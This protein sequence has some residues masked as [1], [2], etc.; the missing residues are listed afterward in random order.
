MAEV[1]VEN[2]RYIKKPEI[3]EATPWTGDNISVMHKQ[4][5]KCSF[6]IKENNVL[7]TKEYDDFKLILA[8]GDVLMKSLLDGDINSI[9]KEV[10]E[11]EWMLLNHNPN[12]NQSPEI[13]TP[14]VCE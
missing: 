2:N 7:E 3:F 1:I 6:E 12:P 5:P 14:E 9:N 13:Q 11:N 10:F 4:F 8:V